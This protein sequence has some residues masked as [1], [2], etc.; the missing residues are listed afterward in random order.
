[1]IQENYNLNKYVIFF[2]T[3]FLITPP[4]NSWIKLFS[5]SIL[6]II[7]F[8]SDKQNIFLKRNFFWIIPI[9]ILISVKFYSQNYNLIVNQ[10]VLTTNTSNN[11]QYL[12]KNFDNNLV[13]LITKELSKLQQDEIL[14]RNVKTPGLSERSTLF[15]KFAFQAESHW[16]NLDEGKYI[17]IKKKLNFWDLGPASLNDVDLNFGDTKKTKY[18]TNLYFPVFFKINFKKINNKSDLCFKGHIFYYDFEKFIEKNSEILSC[19]KI[20]Y[21]KDYY[22]LDTKRDLVIEIKKNLFFNH[23]EIIFYFSTFSILIILFIS[24][25]NINLYY[26]FYIISFYLILFLYFKFGLQPISGYSETIYFDRGMDGMAHYGYARI[27]LNNLFQGNFYT[28]MMGSEEIFY[29]M[30]ITRYINSFLMFFFGDNILGSLFLISFFPIFIFKILNIYLTNKISFI[31][32]F[33]FLFIPIFE[34]LGFTIINYISFTVDGYGE[35]LSY[36]FLVV[37]SYFY[38]SKDN[39]YLKFFLIGFLSFLVIGIRPNYLIFNSIL[40]IS[41]ICYLKF[42]NQNIKNT[43]LKIFLI[44]IGFAFVLLIPL[45]NYIY[46]EELVFLVKTDNIQN[47][48]HIKL[49][50]YIYLF[51]SLLD[52]NFDYELFYKIKKHL[53]NYIK[54]YEFWFFVTLINLLFILFCKIAIKIK[55]FSISLIFMHLTYLFFLGDPRYSMGCWLLSFIVLI[56]SCKIIYFPYLKAKFFQ[57]NNKSV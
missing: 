57:Q 41:Y 15:K 17:L 35:G 5:I 36:L 19:I 2:L 32:T 47:S 8:T 52:L 25:K 23:L 11:F 34:A 10:V 20:D 39:T 6:I 43:I 55:I 29:Y 54:I 22:F 49:N 44:L 56:Y 30:P 40:I 12:K 26:L 33:F 9:I 3:L 31:L 14:L 38:F 37:I 50:D 21:K 42:Y 24:F 45:H 16:N 1:M 7:I 27:I 4:F 13:K 53:F 28:A 51:N 48:Y 18:Q 46:S